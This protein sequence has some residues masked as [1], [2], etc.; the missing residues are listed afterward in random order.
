LKEFEN[1]DAPF[2]QSLLFNTDSGPI[3]QSDSGIAFNVDIGRSPLL[4]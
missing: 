1:I 2:A 3:G 4:K